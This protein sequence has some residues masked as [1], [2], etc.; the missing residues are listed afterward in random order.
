MQRIINNT[1]APIFRRSL[2]Q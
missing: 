2:P 1:V